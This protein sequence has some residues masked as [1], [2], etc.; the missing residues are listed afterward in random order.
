M[1]VTNREDFPKNIG[2]ILLFHSVVVERACFWLMA[3]QRSIPYLD[4]RYFK[5]FY[6][7]DFRVLKYSY[8]FATKQRYN[9]GYQV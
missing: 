8:Y 2:L 4:T 5:S 3:N 9:T 1:L 6:F 7:S